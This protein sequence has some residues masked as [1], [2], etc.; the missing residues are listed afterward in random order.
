VVKKKGVERSGENF[1][2]SEERS[3]MRKATDVKMQIRVNL[4]Q[5]LVSQGLYCVIHR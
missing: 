5:Y 4:G 2:G 1:G 3:V